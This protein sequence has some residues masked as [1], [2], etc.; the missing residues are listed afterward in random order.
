ML[1]EFKCPTTCDACS[2][3]VLPMQANR[4]SSV[5]LEGSRADLAYDE[6]ALAYRA[7]QAIFNSLKGR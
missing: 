7:R 6:R 5:L 2:V 4:I 1:K 3:C